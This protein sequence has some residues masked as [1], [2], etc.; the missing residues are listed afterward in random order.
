MIFFLKNSFVLKK[1]K[2][3][4]TYNISTLANT[5]GN[6]P[7]IGSITLDR[8]YMSSQIILDV[9]NES[10][11]NNN[12]RTEKILI[13]NQKNEGVKPHRFWGSKV[14]QT[15]IIIKELNQLKKN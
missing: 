6:H 14:E 7:L 4:N 15:D 10:I 11:R 5:Y 12:D 3:N 9:A 8:N 1:N 13:S 2:K